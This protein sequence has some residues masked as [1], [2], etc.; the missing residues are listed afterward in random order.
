VVLPRAN[1]Q[2]LAEIPP[3]ILKGLDVYLVERVEDVL[4]LALGPEA[5]CG[6]PAARKASARAAGRPPRG[7]KRRSGR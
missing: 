2:D 7:R 4:P 3:E 5:Q 6:T 1:E